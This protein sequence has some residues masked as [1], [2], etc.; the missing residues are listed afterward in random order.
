VTVS[1]EG[2]ASSRGHAGLPPVPGVTVLG[3]LGRGA[4]A[5]TYRVRRDG[6]D[7][8]MKV[9]AGRAGAGRAA[10]LALRREAAQL[11]WVNHPGLTAVHEVGQIADQA[12]MIMDLVDGR[13]LA[14]VLAT[15]RLPVAEAVRLGLALA[16]VLA[17]VH[18]VGLVHR[19]VKPQN[20][21][22]E[23][24][25]QARLIDFGL[26]A[27]TDRDGGDQVGGTFLYAAPEQ[28][29]VI[30]RPVDGRSDLY[31][32]GAVLFECL[33]GRT[34][35]VAQDTGTLLQMHAT[36]PT[37]ALA[38]HLPDAPA[39]LCSIVARL[40][41]KD[42]DDRYPDAAELVADLALLT[43]PADR[44]EVA[45]DR[46]ERPIGRDAQLDELRA[47]WDRAR[48]GHGGVALVTG[49]PGAGKTRMAQ[50][51]VAVA[52][53][54]GGGVLRACCMPG[55]APLAAIRSAIERYLAGDPQ[56]AEADRA[57]R[58]ELVRA[59]ATGLPRVGRLSPALAGLL[60]S[61]PGNGG[62][63][64]DDD[65]A[66][67]SHDLAGFLA[68]LA[69]A[70]GG[71]LCCVDDVHLA[72]PASVA[73]LSQLV[74][75]LDGSPLLVLATTPDRTVGAGWLDPAAGPHATV[76][77]LEALDTDSVR[78]LVKSCARGLEITDELVHRLASRGGMTPFE[79]LEYVRAVVDAG[80]LAPHWGRW[81]LDA[82]GLDAVALPDD[83]YGLMLRRMDGL[84]AASRPVLAVA[85][86][87]GPVF[88][89]GLLER[90]GGPVEV[91]R[92][93][94]DE[95]TGCRVLERRGP[96]LAF[97]HEG[98]RSALLGGLDEAQRRDAHQRIA[99]AM[100]PDAGDDP[101]QVHAIARQYLAGHPGRD[102]DRVARLCLAAGRFALARHA[103]EDAAEFLEAASRLADR[104]PGVTRHEVDELL[105]AARYQAG[106]LTE[107]EE[108]FNRALA[109]V[110]TRP[111]R[112]RVLARLAELHAAV[113][114]LEGSTATVRRA[115][116]E[117]GHRLP[118][119]PVLLIVTTMVSLVAGMVVERTRI[120]FGTTDP[121]LRAR[122]RL[123]FRLH[124]LAAINALFMM[125]PLG[126]VMLTLR[127]LYPASRLGVC[128]E[129]ARARCDTAGLLQAVGLPSG[130]SYRLAR[131]AS[132]QVGDPAVIEYVDW[133]RR[134][135][136]AVLGTTGARHIA[137][138]V[139]DRSR[140]VDTG[141][142]LNILESSAFL[143]L[144]AGLA[145]DAYLLYEEGTRRVAEADLA[146]N[147][148]AV[149]G[150]AAAAALGRVA[151]SD[152]LQ[153]R[154]DAQTPRFTNRGD[155]HARLHAAVRAAVEQRDFAAFDSAV[156]GL[157]EMRLRP[158]T[159]PLPNRSVHTAIAYGRIEQC[160]A[161]PADLRPA[162]LAAAERAARALRRATLGAQTMA[163]HHVVVRAYLKHLHGDHQGA[164]ASLGAAE[165]AL[166]DADA[167]LV[168][169]EAARLRARAL[170][171]L[172]RPQDAAAQAATA[173]AVADQHGWPHRANWI[174]T[175]FGLG[176]TGL[177]RTA[178]VVS[179]GTHSVDRQ[180][181]AAVERLS[182]AAARIL[183]PVELT[184]VAL[185]EVIRLLG[186]ERAYLFLADDD[187]RLQPRQ[188]RDAAGAD[189]TTLTGY[190]STLVERVR[191]GRETLVVTGT[192]EGLALG[193]Q[194]VL[195]HGLRSIMV[196]PLLLDGRLLGVVYLDSR[197][198][199]GMFTEADAGVLAALTTHVA[200]ALE[201]ARAA[202]LAV[203]VRSAR[204]ERDIAETLR[205]ATAYLSGTLDPTT[206]LHRL[207]A[208]VRR[209]L[210]AAR[211]WLAVL[212]GEKL[213]AWDE[214]DEPEESILAGEPELTAL[215][216]ATAPVTGAA[217]QPPPAPFGA[218]AGTPWLALPLHARQDIVGVLVLAAP[219]PAGFRDGQVEISAALAGQ[220]MTAY[221]N[222]RLFAQVER[223]ATTDGL[224]GLFNRRH[225]F[226]M[227]TR[228]LA[229]AARRSS[230]LAAVMLDID[231]FKQV[232]DVHGHPV[233]D[234]VIATVARR[235]GA[236]VRATDLVGR[237]GGE[238]F[239]II[240]LD[241]GAADALALAE[242]LRAAIG[243]RPVKT[244]AGDL[245]VTISVGI[246][247]LDA[248]GDSAGDLLGRADSALYQAKRGGRNR[249][250][251]A[252]A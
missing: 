104:A 215:L 238:E 161:A 194:S 177:S 200:T 92:T 187:G 43:D 234:D 77:T 30:K 162:A 230:P 71:L 9:Y 183:D 151:E 251:Q 26:A 240:L 242:R 198:A 158:V 218:A 157:A 52:G 7:W 167:P 109:S 156:A 90:V 131:Q 61:V 245:P 199:K 59:A 231:H 190:G 93:A 116:A 32:L 124:H 73:V 18:R 58:A 147:S 237:Y 69:R 208:T 132:A 108:D 173:L 169:Y 31:A 163:A 35:F 246:A 120:G 4:N 179:S 115:L 233:G 235:L 79:V 14:D 135:M 140:L 209:T 182:I 152:A 216:A 70:H 193:S 64:V 21:M 148:V 160:L 232:N 36:M 128:A 153:R 113:G 121:A 229:L 185:D 6:R 81:Q 117:L 188:G 75:R 145:D 211:S 236:T 172:G 170:A 146:T 10:L 224:T 189:L 149:W 247:C 227:A 144:D 165:R 48:S 196:A 53:R 178:Q 228:E 95:A 46:R 63:A 102:P 94:L 20:I 142:Y 51:L 25:G 222:A 107:A 85:A 66:R 204:R 136:P 49:G 118:A 241:T 17:A 29:G 176:T 248:A 186:A 22:L 214:R 12:Y 37:P 244:E 57:R 84:G 143:L 62:V 76:V 24:G 55:A 181:L 56:A 203:E 40:L 72:D 114:D 180:R 250:A 98:I 220:G 205:D 123:R 106:R 226:T 27:R 184:R 50:E 19:D 134:S 99:E 101:D 111:D 133:V 159:M 210:P 126:C 212:D 155:R 171:A 15:D 139:F 252:T 34:P 110:P 74:G 195:A 137:S 202:E 23:P 13:P 217:D 45:T 221:E 82:D 122:L 68:E 100:G 39:Q 125:D 219:D 89:P 239:A 150:I 11:T 67:L 1:P 103:S 83:V 201:T 87:I 8:A 16:D 5:V 138:T 130:R 206:V 243:D 47:A 44:P 154:S 54:D 127:G 28:S 80:L 164:L 112:A 249:V 166:H 60:G 191:A 141:N 175:T 192:E 33:T 96:L 223:L 88:A 174:R 65:P 129:Y 105:G 2:P 91:V 97:V 197:V 38:D 78:R 168:T 3:E 41:A 86:A 42:P 225:F 119:N 207:H 213:Q